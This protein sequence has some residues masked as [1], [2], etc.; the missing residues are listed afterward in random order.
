MRAPREANLARHSTCSNSAE[1]Q[2]KIGSGSGRI[3]TLLKDKT[4]DAIVEELTSQA[5]GRPPRPDEQAR[6]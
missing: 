2:A 6:S 3:S 4:D 5:L 1:L